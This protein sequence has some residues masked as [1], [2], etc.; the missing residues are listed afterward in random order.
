VLAT[1]ALA[2]HFTMLG[3]DGQEYRLPNS[4]SGQPG[5][6]VFFKT[7]C[8]TCDLTFPYINRLRESH[9]AG[10]HV[11]AVA[12][13]PPDRATDY[14]REH[15]INFPVLID[16]PDYTVSKLYD[17]A[18][19]PTLFLIDDRGRTAYSTYGFAKDDL[20]EVARRLAAWLSEPPVLIAPAD[21][22]HPA[23]KPG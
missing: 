10:W 1:G 8:E 2:P 18:A 9:P 17:P 21:D 13:D 3:I 14:A 16:A 11:W 5:L 19:T 15:G 6:L 7:T 23:F 4:R 20:N 12:Q 22:G